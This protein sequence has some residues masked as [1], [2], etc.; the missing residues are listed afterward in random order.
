MKIKFIIIFFALF[1]GV[2]VLHAQFNPEFS[3]LQTSLSFNNPASVG[4]NQGI[5]AT[6][7]NRNQWLGFNGAPK[8][9]LFLINAPIKLIGIPS[10]LGLTLYDDKAG[11]SHNFNLKAQ[12]SYHTFIGSAQLG[13]GAGLGV[14]NLSYNGEWVSTV[15]ASADASIPNIGENRMAFDAQLGLYYEND[16]FKMAFS[17]DHFNKPNIKFVDK[18]P[19]YIARHYYMYSSYSF[20][21]GKLGLNVHPDVLLTSDGTNIQFNANIIG[22]YNN[23]FFGGISYKIGDIAALAGI[24]LLD[25]IEIGITYG[26]ASNKISKFSSEIYFKYCFD[27]QKD[28]K[29]RN[30]KSVR[31]L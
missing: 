2:K 9:T 30:Y 27:F 3:F 14:V 31:F 17:V 20:E 7:L 10:G 16:N 12:Y 5:C 25:G 13:I 15:A 1:L 11:L 19:P 21:L 26:I 28:K 23:K 22:D 4:F 24:R 8:T 29:A 6:A 18:N